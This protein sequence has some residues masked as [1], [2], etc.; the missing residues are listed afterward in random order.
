MTKKT[1]GY[2]LNQYQ[3]DAMSFRQESANHM[4]VLLNLAGE[5]G[6]LNS[7]IA[8][9]IRDGQKEDFKVQACKELGDILW[10]VAGVA[11][12]MGFTL[13]DVGL[14]NIEKLMGRVER[15]TLTG[16]SGDDR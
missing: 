11:A 7:L 5:V 1:D 13:Q 16:A 3:Q 2:T 9:A 12:D 8:K 14:T 10:S 4:Y 6:E 15:G